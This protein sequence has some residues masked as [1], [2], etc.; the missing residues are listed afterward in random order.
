[1]KTTIKIPKNKL[2]KAR[3]PVAN[4]PNVYHKDKNKYDRKRDKKDIEKIYRK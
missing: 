3:I 1:M 2:P 4:K